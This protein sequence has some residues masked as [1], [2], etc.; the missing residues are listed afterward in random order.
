MAPLVDHYRRLGVAPSASTEEIRVAYRALANKFHPDRAMA[1]S[2]AE[3]LLA[4][5]RMREIN[6]SWSVLHDP[7]SRRRYD[8]ARVRER[9]EAGRP[10]GGGPTARPAPLAE[11]PR[12]QGDDL[13]EVAPTGISAGLAR[14]LPWVL[15]VVLL[16]GIFVVTAYAGGDEPAPEAPTVARQGS[17]IDVYPGPSTTI[18]A[19]DG[20][21][22]LVVVQRVV[23][24]EPCPAGTEERRFGVDD[25]VDCVRPD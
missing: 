2:P 9:R 14:H 15:L 19:C 25:L 5:R 1:G 20:P 6:E 22:E 21:H 8:D 7:L 11:R 17:C 4:E 23:S 12:P 13:V 3:L 24:G 16:V 10:P 18:V